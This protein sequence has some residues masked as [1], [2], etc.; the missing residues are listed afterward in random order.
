M[1]LF[2]FFITRLRFKGSFTSCE[3]FDS[4]LA[5]ASTLR[6]GKMG[7]NFKLVGT[8]KGRDIVIHKMHI[9]NV[10]KMHKLFINVRHSHIVHSQITYHS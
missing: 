3:T 10:T 2:L 5:R 9:I 4:R 7:L 6:I 8:D 1:I